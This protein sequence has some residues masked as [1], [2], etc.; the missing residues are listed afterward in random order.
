VS[1]TAAPMGRR[2][3]NAEVGFG[4]SDLDARSV[5][6]VLFAGQLRTRARAT[7]ANARSPGAGGRRGLLAQAFLDRANQRKRGLRLLVRWIEPD[8]LREVRGRLGPSLLL[9]QRHAEVEAGP[10]M[11][12]LQAHHL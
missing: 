12:G 10:R 5:A 9:C 8:R 11:V 2:E 4:M 3:R 6:F 1:R 7:R